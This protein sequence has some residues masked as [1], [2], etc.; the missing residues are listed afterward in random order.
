MGDDAAGRESQ[1]GPEARSP[2]EAP[3]TG[4]EAQPVPPGSAPP[5]P[6]TDQWQQTLYF[7]PRTAESGQESEPRQEPSDARLSAGDVASAGPGNWW[8]QPIPDPAPTVPAPVL[9]ET[10]PPGP[11]ALQ[12]P[13]EPERTSFWR[14][15]WEAAI[16][17]ALAFGIAFVIKLFVVQPF[18]IPSGSMEPTL[19]PGDRVLVN[20]FIY[21]FRNPEPGDIVVFVAPRDVQER[22]FIKRVVAVEGQT[23][24]VKDGKL[25]VDGKARDEAYIASTR[26][27][28]TFGPVTVADDNVFVMGDNR[29]N[30]SDSRVFGPFDRDR[31]V[32]EAFATYWPLSRMR[33][34]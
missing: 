21:R 3:Q 18:Y 22:D 27:H 1:S 11:A 9:S 31:I 6:Q 20:K 16:L 12:E 19:F 29:S 14:W 8:E 24:E 25:Y 23:V 5:G 33:G 13:A 28:A 34:L 17:V 4:E 2:Q 7:G 26:D 32:G 10:A 15:L 30:S